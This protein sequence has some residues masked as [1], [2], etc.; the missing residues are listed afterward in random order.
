MP[1]V[2]KNEEIARFYDGSTGWLS[3][4]RTGRRQ[5]NWFLA[6]QVVDLG[7]KR[8]NNKDIGEKADG[9]T[10]RGGKDGNLFGN[11]NTHSESEKLAS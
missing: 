7:T 10:I 1:F 9:I 8:R 3:A 4:Q 11:C 5:V 6:A 2:Q